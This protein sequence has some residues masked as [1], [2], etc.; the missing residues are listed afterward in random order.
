[1]KTNYL[2]AMAV[3]MALFL[4]AFNYKPNTEIRKDKQTVVY[5]I[6]NSGAQ[7]AIGSY[8]QSTVS[9]TCIPPR[10]RLCALRIS[11]NN[12]V[13]TQAELN[14]IFNSLDTDS[15]GTLD[16]QSESALLIKKA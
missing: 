11:D 14:P 13:I 15:D 1:M 6:Y 10:T 4:C 12:G 16:D 8:T 2:P 5:L 9:P 7:N 3:L